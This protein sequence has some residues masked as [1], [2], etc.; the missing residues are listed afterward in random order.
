VYAEHC[1]IKGNVNV[2]LKYDSFIPNKVK[3]KYAKYILRVHRS[4]A[5]IAI[6]AELGLYTF[7]T[8]AHT[9][10]LKPLFTSFK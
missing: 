8:A 1:L 5:N 6:L 9:K 10:Y 3:M 7:P 4:A 2:E